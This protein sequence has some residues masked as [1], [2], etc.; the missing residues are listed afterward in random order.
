RVEQVEYLPAQLDGGLA[1]QRE[2]VLNRDVDVEQPR[3]AQDVASGIPQGA[4][5]DRLERRL[6]EPRVDGLRTLAVSD[7][8]RQSGHQVADVVVALRDRDRPPGA[9][10][11]DAADVEAV[12]QIDDP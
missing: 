4:G 3:P 10:G 8:V 2:A 1:R 7:T 5:R 6:V 9:R 11:G 12:R